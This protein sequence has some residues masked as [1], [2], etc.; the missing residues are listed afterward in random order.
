MTSKTSSSLL[1]PPLAFSSQKR[2][3]C[4]GRANHPFRP[5]GTS[6][7]NFLPEIPAPPPVTSACL[8]EVCRG[9][10]TGVPPTLRAGASV[11]GTDLGWWLCRQ[12]T[13][14]SLPPGFWVPL[15][16]DSARRHCCFLPVWWLR[17]SCSQVSEHKLC[18][19]C[20]IEGVWQ[21][22]SWLI[23]AVS[24]QGLRGQQ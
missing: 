24:A 21:R 11:W 4:P 9:V 5:A 19:C 18:S 10:V 17:E 16:P 20:D 23:A 7:E 12:P 8:W 2:W 15:N 1:P 3:H 13:R 22:S 6:E 14:S